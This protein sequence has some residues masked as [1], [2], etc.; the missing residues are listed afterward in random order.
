MRTLEARAKHNAIDDAT[1]YALEGTVGVRY[2][3]VCGRY[4]WFCSDEGGPISKRRARD[5]LT[6][7]LWNP[8]FAGSR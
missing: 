2:Y 4:A 7:G 3:P 5:L 1:G 8:S 6:K